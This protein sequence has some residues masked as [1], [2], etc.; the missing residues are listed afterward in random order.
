MEPQENEW[1]EAISDKLKWM[2]HHFDILDK[3]ITEYVDS[4]NIQFVAKRYNHANTEAWGNIESTIGGVGLMVISHIFGDVLQSANSTLDYLVCE[5]FR[6]HNPGEESKPSHRFPIVNTRG[7]FNKE[8]GSDALFGIPFEAIAVIEGLQSYEGRTDP[9]N[10]RLT[11]LRTL[12][13]IHKHRKIHV[14]ALIANP[15]PSDPTAIFEKDGEPFTKIGY[16]PEVTYIKADI[17]PFPITD[18]GKVDMDCK[19]SPVVVLEEREFRGEIVNLL[20]ARLCEAVGE[21]RNRLA[22]FF[23]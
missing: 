2:S 23:A 22:P 8:I 7:A 10:A 12:T 16:L 14:S 11:A 9:V 3:A 4:N 20:A 19:F 1:L 18:E 13:N 6:R 21:C 17:G 5:L 15:A